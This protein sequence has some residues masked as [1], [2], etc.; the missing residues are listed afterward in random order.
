MGS[1]K[2]AWRLACNT[3]K[4]RYRWHD[5]RHSFVTRLAE[6]PL[7]SEGTI[8]ALAGHV[9]KKMLDRYS[10]V[11]VAAKQAAITALERSSSTTL[12]SNSETDG[13]Q[14]GAQPADRPLLN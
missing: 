1:W 11:R 8:K 4:A 7:V 13:A 14:N 3:A 9:S 5:C 10:H 2:K 12:T 6:N